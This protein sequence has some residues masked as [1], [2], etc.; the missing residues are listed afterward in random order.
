MEHIENDR[1]EEAAGIMFGIALKHVYINQDYANDFLEMALLLL[2]EKLTK[3]GETAFV[4]KKNTVLYYDNPAFDDHSLTKQFLDSLG[5]LGLHIV[6]LMPDSR[7][8]S[9]P[10]TRKVIEKYK[11]DIVTFPAGLSMLDTY[12]ALCDSILT[13]KPEYAFFYP[14]PRDV[15]GLLAFM[16]FKGSMTRFMFDITDHAFW[17]GRNAFDYFLECR[18]YGASLA[19]LYRGIPEEKILEFHY[20][21]VLPDIPFKGYPFP[22]S[23]DDFIIF[24]GGNVY[25]TLDK[26]LTFYNIVYNMLTWHKNVKFWYAMENQAPG[27]LELKEKFPDR[28]FN[29]S[30]R[31]DLKE[32]FR[33]S[34]MFLN[35]YPMFGGST[36]V[37]AA[38]SLCPPFTLKFNDE[39]YGLLRN[40]EKLGV[41]FNNY[42]D[43][44]KAIDRYIKDAAYRNEIKGNMKNAIYTRDEMIEYMRRAIFERRPH[45]FNIAEP[46]T[47]DFRAWHFKVF[48]SEIFS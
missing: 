37:F 22:K 33:H 15:P 2:N 26:G 31:D 6:Y 11:G 10:K 7:L 36:M 30:I 41:I 13:V 39:V 43:I 42:N 5:A 32:V 44:L 23:D 17:I 38:A 8:D 20:S 35:T 18:N 3:K 9:I 47:R 46:E 27:F 14:I 12:Y 16:R 24:S 28:V 25:K 21:P 34:D 4:A 40:D 45:T 19:V 29:T 1:L 48:Q